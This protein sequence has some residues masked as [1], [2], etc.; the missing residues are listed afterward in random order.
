MF[1]KALMLVSRNFIMSHVLNFGRLWIAFG[2]PLFHT[3]N[4]CSIRFVNVVVV[5]NYGLFTCLEVEQA[6]SE[7]VQKLQ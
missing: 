6:F 3:N 4:F 2:L 1:T 7:L 5:D